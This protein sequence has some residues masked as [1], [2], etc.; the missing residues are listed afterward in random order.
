MLERYVCSYGIEFDGP[1]FCLSATMNAAQQMETGDFVFVAT[2]GDTARSR[3]VDQ[4]R[5]GSIDHP[6]RMNFPM[7]TTA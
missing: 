5:L 6:A 3:L 4:C 1:K 2:D 7:S